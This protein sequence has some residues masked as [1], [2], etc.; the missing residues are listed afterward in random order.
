MSFKFKHA[1]VAVLVLGLCAALFPDVA[2][3]QTALGRLKKMDDD[4]SQFTT[5]QLNFL[6]QTQKATVDTLTSAINS[7]DTTTTGAVTVAGAEYVSLL[8]KNNWTNGL[9]TLELPDTLFVFGAVSN[10]GSNYTSWF[11]VDT[12]FVA[13]NPGS[14]TGPTAGWNGVSASAS[15]TTSYR[16]IQ[17]WPPLQATSL[18]SMGAPA[19]IAGSAGGVASVPRRSVAANRLAEKGIH[20]P[21]FEQMK[22]LFR[23]NNQAADTTAISAQVAIKKPE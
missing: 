22:F 15:D 17:L 9:G 19:A 10:D 11:P 16:P 6:S 13:I 8:L 3:G 1:W 23:T 14:V 7:T 20:L 21:A 5:H 18:D 4:R 12:V 2:Q